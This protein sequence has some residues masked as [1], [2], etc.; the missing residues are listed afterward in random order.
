MQ[1]VLR[2]DSIQI[3]EQIS[4]W[5]EAIALCVSPLIEHGDV[6]ASYQNALYKNIEAYG[7]NFIVT[8]YVILPHA[9]PEQGVLRNAVSM[10]LI[11]RG[12]HFGN[13]KTPV[14]LMIILAPVDSN[15]HLQLLRQISVILHEG[16]TIKKIIEAKTV[17]E[18]QHYISMELPVEECEVR[19]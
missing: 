5:K 9:R 8:P 2:S 13:P 18:I 12:F 14:K 1:G 16:D 11:R 6:E 7:N 19:K 4:H 17:F 10:L 3:V 15:S